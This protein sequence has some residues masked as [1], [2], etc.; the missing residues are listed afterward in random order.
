[1]CMKCEH[2]CFLAFS[3]VLCISGFED[4][5]PF[6]KD[7]NPFSRRFLCSKIPWEIR[8]PLLLDSNPFSKISNVSKRFESP[9]RGFEPPTY[10]GQKASVFS[11][12]SFFQTT[13]F[14]PFHL[15]IQIWF[16]SA[17][18]PKFL[19]NPYSNTSFIIIFHKILIPNIKSLPM[20]PN[21]PK[22]TK[23]KVILFLTHL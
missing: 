14:A 1:M 7:S 21:P 6:N 15:Q 20:D 17:F 22:K 10:L 13:I 18:W 4:F 2:V 9:Y 16:F 8:I 12:V 19:T 11:K 5:N 23:M 3:S